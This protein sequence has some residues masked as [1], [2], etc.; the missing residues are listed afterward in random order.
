MTTL[1]NHD[2]FHHVLQGWK[3]SCDRRQRQDF[4]LTCH[5]VGVLQKTNISGGYPTPV[6]LPNPSHIHP[7]A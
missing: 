6:Y 5:E 2:V 7:V 3:D 4:S 1:S